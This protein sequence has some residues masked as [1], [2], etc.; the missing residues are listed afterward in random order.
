MTRRLGLGTR[1][2]VYV[3]TVLLALQLLALLFYS[4]QLDDRRQERLE[5][6]Q[7]VAQNIAVAIDT[8]LRD[9]E[10]TS[11]AVA[12]ALAVQARIEQPVAGPYLARVIAEYPSLRAIFV[13]DTAGRVIATNATGLGVDLSTRPY[14]VTLRGGAEK[15]WSGS[16]V[17]I[18]TG[19]ITVAF[20]RRIGT[21]AAARGYLVFAFHPERLLSG[22]A[23]AG[24]EDSEIVLTDDRGLVLY[25]SRRSALTAAERDLSAVTAVQRALRGELVRIS[26]LPLLGEARYGAIVPV[27]SVDWAVGYLRPQLPFDEALRGAL[28]GQIALASVALVAAGLLLV[29]SASRLTR[30]IAQLA[31]EA[32]G[33]ARGERPAIGVPA[34]AGVEVEQLGDAMHAMSEAVAKREDELRFLA[35]ASAELGSSLNYR[36]TLA[37]VARQALGR[38]ADWCTID[39]VENGEIH[40]VEVAYA[41]P[42]VEQVAHAFATSHAPRL[43]ELEHR[44]ARVIRTGRSEL[45]PEVSDETIREYA[46]GDG[47]RDRLARRISARST[48]TVPLLLRGAAL[49]AITFV[50]TDPVRRYGPRD[51]AVAEDLAR[52]A[53][54]AIENS[55]LYHEVQSALRT[56]DEFLSAVAHELKTP[57]TTIKGFSQLLERMVADGRIDPAAFRGTLTRIDLATNRMNS[58]VEELLDLARTQLGEA[59]VLE[60][61]AVDLAAL[62]REVAADHVS[63]SGRHS[64]RVDAVAEPTVGLWDRTRLER[65]LHN[66]LSNAVKYSPAGGEIVVR[67]GNDADVAVLEVVDHGIGIPPS[68]LERI[69]VRFSRGSNV[70]GRI[71]GTGIGLTLVRQIVEQ[72]GGLVTFESVLEQGTTFRV[73]LPLAPP[74]SAIEMRGEAVP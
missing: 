45:V 29:G 55:R 72:H 56:R 47:E 37:R 8:H 57:L 39:V 33:I 60:R 36:E 1:L 65:V 41:D 54:A 17:G 23:L 14:L 58:T 25:D 27:P 46:M 73:R 26:D 5:N 20:G 31:R 40:R 24:A 52:R 32:G 2:S 16:L 19:E 69:F 3:L 61:S 34:S 49:G 51:L 28:L 74:G 68:D 50:S 44:E 4:A 67:I 64:I 18:E 38:L 6:V 10:S 59:P 42:A 22:L 30:P 21:A 53:A 15:V 35:E 70:I 7:S 62:V 63:S 43:D 48:M 71:G 66:L 12:E 11:V 9:I 13:T